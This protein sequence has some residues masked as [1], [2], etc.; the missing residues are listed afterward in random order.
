MKSKIIK[1]LAEYDFYNGFNKKMDKEQLLK[2]TNLHFRDRSF[3]DLSL[4]LDE[5]IKNFD[6]AES[7][8]INEKVRNAYFEIIS[9]DE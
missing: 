2:I 7:D 8:S 6:G 3:G 5:C 4:I 1:A 9:C